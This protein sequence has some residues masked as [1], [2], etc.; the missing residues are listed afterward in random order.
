MELDRVMPVTEAARALRITPARVRSLARSGALPATQ[1]A[2]RWVVD[3]HA[4]ADRAAGTPTAG[5]PLSPRAAW[6][7]LDMLDGRGGA[8]PSG[9]ASRLR[10]R[11][12]GLDP[13]AE[14]LRWRTWLSRRARMI[15]YSA[16]AAALADLLQDPRVVRGAASTRRSTLP[17]GAGV[18]TPDE[19][20]YLSADAL[21]P[22]VDEY[23]LLPSAQPNLKIHV[24]DVP[25][26]LPANNADVPGS[27]EAADLL[28][29]DDSRS[30]HAGAELL[31][32]L[33]QRWLLQ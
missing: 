2:G 17:P 16:D 20:I 3:R 13:H 11:A 33:R 8:L 1:V 23:A 31:A 15:A 6:A 19:E 24:T 29:R 18:A 27:V 28:D 12:K 21:A 25:W 14:P 26:P 4:V 30:R 9:E 10:T 32:R 22:L 5:R 7:L